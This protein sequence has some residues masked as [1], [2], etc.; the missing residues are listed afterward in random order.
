[1][2]VLARLASNL[3]AGGLRESLRPCPGPLIGRRSSLAAQMNARRMEELQAHLPF[4]LLVPPE[5]EIRRTEGL[6]GAVTISTREVIVRLETRPCTRSA[7]ELVL[8]RLADAL[9][10]RRR[11]NVPTWSS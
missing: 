9:E 10:A 8:R 5:G 2:Y 1:M 4:A 6:A 3:S 11:L 7:S